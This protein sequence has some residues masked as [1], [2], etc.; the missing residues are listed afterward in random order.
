MIEGAAHNDIVD[1]PAYRDAV[2]NFLREGSA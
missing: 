1:F 2:R